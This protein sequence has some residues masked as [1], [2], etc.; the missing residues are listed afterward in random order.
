MSRLHLRIVLAIAACAAFAMPALSVPAAQAAAPGTGDIGIYDTI[1]TFKN[2][3]TGRCL[4]SIAIDWHQTYTCLYDAPQQ[5]RVHVWADGTRRLES[6][7]RPNYCLD[8]SAGGG[9]RVY[10]PCN[11]LT[12]QS[13]WI[14]RNS[15]GSIT[16]RN[17][18]TGNCL[19]DSDA[20]GLRTFTC[21]WNSFQ[22]WF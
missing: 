20:F 13:W 21:Y 9:L 3:N 14:D 16:F 19:D 10:S 1:N 8:D 7:S 18:A 11:D 12:Y 15:D 22:S 4:D 6:V 5:W 2:L 17:Q